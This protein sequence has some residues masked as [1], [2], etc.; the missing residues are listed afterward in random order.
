MPHKFQIVDALYRLAKQMNIAPAERC[1]PL[2]V[3]NSYCNCNHRHGSINLARNIPSVTRFE[4]AA[5]IS[6]IIPRTISSVEVTDREVRPV[7]YRAK[8]SSPFAI[9]RDET[10]E[11]PSG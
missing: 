9:G 3:M 11:V 4:R 8:C 10:S 7:L 5:A 6:S 2:R 1:L